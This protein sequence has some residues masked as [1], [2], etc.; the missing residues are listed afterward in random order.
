[1]NKVFVYGTLRAKG[2]DATHYLDGYTMYNAG[3]YPYLLEN[4]D[5]DCPNQVRGEVKEVSDLELA[6]MDIYEGVDKGL[7]DR[8]EVPVFDMENNELDFVWLYV[9]KAFPKIVQSGD[10]FNRE[11]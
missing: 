4:K 3:P 7:Y 5:Y 10:W 2:K 6:H 11:T 8:V 9:G 1:M